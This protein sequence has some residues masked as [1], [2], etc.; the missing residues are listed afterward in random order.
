MKAKISAVSYFLPP[1]VIDNIQLSAKYP[2]AGDPDRIFKATGIR[3]RKYSQITTVEMAKIAVE[4]LF[5]RANV[6]REDIDCVI[7]STVTADH[8][9]PASANSLIYKIGTTKAFGVD[10]GT[11]CPGFLYALQIGR[12]FIQ[13]NVAKKVLVVGSERLSKIINDEDYKTGILFGDGTGVILLEPVA[14][15]EL[16][17]NDVLLKTSAEDIDDIYM[18]TPF[19][20]EDWSQERFQLA[21]KRVL[22]HGINL[23]RDIILEYLQKHSLSLNDFDFVLSH[24]ANVRL[25]DGLIEQLS[26]P[27]EKF[28]MNIAEVGNTA[29]ASI[30]ILLAQKIDAGIIHAGQR[31]LMVS[32]GSGYSLAVVD[33]YI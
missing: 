6:R 7:F 23:T 26:V 3:T 13:T 32:F 4:D 12:M 19:N 5:N 1:D 2:D 31:L 11:A 14:D 22:R 10:V 16:G 28:L 18:K 27:P 17:I 8:F 15:G 20:T 30:P 21:G 29:S 25:V 9:F 33:T 24:Q